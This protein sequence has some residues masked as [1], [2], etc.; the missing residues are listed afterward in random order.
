[1][2]DH[3][4]PSKPQRNSGSKAKPFFLTD[5][6]MMAAGLPNEKFG[7]KDSPLLLIFTFADACNGSGIF[8]ESLFCEKAQNENINKKAIFRT[9]EQTVL[10]IKKRKLR[11]TKLVH[12]LR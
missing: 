8:S 6:L 2:Y 10:G 5:K 7:N 3:G 9:G 4:L 1:M 12:T 11:I